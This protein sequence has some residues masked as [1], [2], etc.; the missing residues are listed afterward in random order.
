[1]FGEK[2]SKDIDL[3]ALSDNTVTRLINDMAENIE[4]EPI[5][6]IKESSFYSLQLD[7]TT[8]V[9][10]DGQLICYVRYEFNNDIREDMLFSKTGTS[11][12]VASP[13]A[14]GLLQ[15]KEGF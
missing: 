13:I 10:N 3:I 9:S 4:S 6:R 7:E 1:M 15:T 12:I 2:L 14:I 8:D 5:S 11:H